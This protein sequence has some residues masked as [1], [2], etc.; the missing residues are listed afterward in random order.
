MALFDVSA[1]ER[2]HSI[3]F[4]FSLLFQFFLLLLHLLLLLLLILLF[5]L[6]L[7]LLSSFSNFDCSL[8]QLHET[9]A[10]RQTG[11]ERERESFEPTAHR[12][13]S[14]I[15]PGALRKN[16]R[17][18]AGRK[19]RTVRGGSASVT[20]AIATATAFSSSWRPSWLSLSSR[21]NVIEWL[22]KLERREVGTTC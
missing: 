1:L 14:R 21:W 20:S 19:C 22:K 8:S 12:N 6:H 7:L 3:F 4:L 9:I 18:R 13:G 15:H 2:F 11:R 16:V 10:E 5:L 17:Q